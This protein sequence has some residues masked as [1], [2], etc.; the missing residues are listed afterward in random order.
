MH[1]YSTVSI[2]DSYLSC[3]WLLKFNYSMSVLSGRRLGQNRRLWWRRNVK[4][5]VSDAVTQW[6]HSDLQPCCTKWQK[7]LPAE[8]TGFC[9]AILLLQQL[10]FSCSPRLFVTTA[11][12]FEVVCLS[13]FT[14]R[15][16]E[17][18]SIH[19]QSHV[20]PLWQ[21]K[22]L[23]FVL[24]WNVAISEETWESASSL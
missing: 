5:T 7:Y 11:L 14:F 23:W 4:P 6:R 17:Q 2:N 3:V 9:P 12:R 24:A 10:M 22:H 21:H 18:S 19:I 8:L 13:L 16:S 20:V 15:A 1:I